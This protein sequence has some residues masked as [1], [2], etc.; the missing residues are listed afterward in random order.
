MSNEPTC[1]QVIDGYMG[2]RLGHIGAL[3]DLADV[4][5]IARLDEITEDKSIREILDEYN[6]DAKKQQDAREGESSVFDEINDAA[7][8]ALQAMPLA[9]T[10]ATVFKIEL[11]TG[12]PAD[13]LEVVCSQT[14]DSTISGSDYRPAGGYEIEKIAYHYAEW[15]DHAERELEDGSHEYEAARQ[16]AERVVPELA[17]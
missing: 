4:Q 6:I 16:F 3:N 2:S 9:V 11:G 1:E 8:D 14:A 13:W 10:A 17:E 7:N 5:D 12:G 15:S